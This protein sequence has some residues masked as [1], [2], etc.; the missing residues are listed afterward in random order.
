MPFP[1][2]HLNTPAHLFLMRKSD[3]H[4]RIED[5]CAGFR[6]KTEGAVRRKRG[7][8]AKSKAICKLPCLGSKRSLS[9]KETSDESN[10]AE[11][12]AN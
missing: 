9:G 6:T 4:Q 12:L 8:P 7:R 1:S 11:D 3:Y 2:Q 10:R 5:L